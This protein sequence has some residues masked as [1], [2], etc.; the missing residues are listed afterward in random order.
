VAEFA[1]VCSYDRA[2]SGWSEW[3]PH[4]RTFRQIVYELHTALA[5]SGERPPFLLVGASYGGWLVRVFQVTYPQQVHG[6]TL[7][8]G[9]TNDPL[10]LAADGRVVRSSDLV[11]NRAIPPVK[12]S[13][14][15]RESDIPPGALAQ[16]KAGLA[17]ASA[18]ANEPPR[19]KLPMVAQQMRTWG[20]RQVGHV[21]AAVNPFEVD[22]LAEL[23]AQASAREYPLGDLPLVVITRGVL[24]ETGDSAR[25]READHRRD[26]AELARMSRR[27]RHI[28]AS[29]S[30][31][32]V[33][34]DDPQ[35]VVG[36]I[37]EMVEAR[38]D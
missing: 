1:R 15:L 6:I 18:R 11:T 10:R 9:G 2:G 24:E 33:Q 37:R 27:G 38:R 20:L 8:D 28:I 34:I 7:V 14:P 17:S 32:H 13:G 36:M 3:G 23:R 26:H 30:G 31:H 16:I 29:K 19:D 22:E 4:P 21:V 5:R 12:T 25:A 35:L